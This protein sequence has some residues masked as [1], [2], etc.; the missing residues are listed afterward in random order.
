MPGPFTPAAAE[1]PPP[2]PHR[3]R[4]ARSGLAAAGF[5]AGPGLPGRRAGLRPAAA[6]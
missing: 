4:P 2:G 3:R 6:D 5:G 1:R